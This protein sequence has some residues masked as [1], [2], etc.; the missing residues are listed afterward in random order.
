M[1]KDGDAFVPSGL[2]AERAQPAMFAETALWP[3]S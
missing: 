2:S 1:H 3:Q